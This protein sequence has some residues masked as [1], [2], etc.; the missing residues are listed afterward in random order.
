MYIMSQIFNDFVSLKYHIHSK[1]KKRK[2][3]T[4]CAVRIVKQYVSGN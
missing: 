4:P 1:I 3:F 2:H